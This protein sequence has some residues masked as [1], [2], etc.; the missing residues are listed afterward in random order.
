MANMI[1]Q[2]IVIILLFALVA[3]PFMFNLVSGLTGGLVTN[4]MTGQPT[5][6]G[7]LIHGA[8]FALLSGIVMRFLRPKK[9]KY[10]Y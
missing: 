3:S 1:V 4:A 9:S 6:T 10:N 5:T 7:L 8:V 2:V